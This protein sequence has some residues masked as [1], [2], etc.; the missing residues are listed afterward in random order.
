MTRRTVYCAITKPGLKSWPP[1]N[2]LANTTIT[3]PARITPTRISN[4]RSW[5][6]R[7]SWPSPMANS[8]SVR[9]N[10]SSTGNSMAAGG[11]GFWPR[12]SASRTARCGHRRQPRGRAPMSS[13]ENDSH[14]V[15]PA[16][17][18]KEAAVFAFRPIIAHYEIGI[19]ADGDDPVLERIG[20]GSRGEIR[21]GQ[22][23][24]VDIDPSAAQLHLLA[25]QADNSFDDEL[26]LH[27]I[28]DHHHVAPPVVA[29]MRQ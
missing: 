6:V 2:R 23:L 4:G 14:Q 12:S 26:V 28:T 10:K 3:E 22:H 29:Q 7:S 25:R 8:T 27:R 20:S 24:T 9:G 1:T 13:L 17:I 5:A 19:G 18:A 15:A 21:F 16:D 11:S